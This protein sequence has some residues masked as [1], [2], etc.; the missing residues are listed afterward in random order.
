MD[1][2]WGWCGRGEYG[3]CVSVCG[4]GEGVRPPAQTQ[5]CDRTWPYLIKGRR[6]L[7]NNWAI[8]DYFYP[9]NRGAVGRG[10]RRKR[11]RGEKGGREGVRE[12]RGEGWLSVRRGSILKKASRREPSVWMHSLISKKEGMKGEESADKERAGFF[13]LLTSKRAYFLIHI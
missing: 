4:G 3:V 1:K 8:K 9:H 13:F 10:R 11:G 7:P 2:G 6:S 5:S 12:Q